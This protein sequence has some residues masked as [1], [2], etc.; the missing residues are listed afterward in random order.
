MQKFVKQ[1]DL[2]IPIIKSGS[3][4]HYTS[5]DGLKGIV[6]GEFWITDREFLNDTKEFHV[7]SKVFKELVKKNIKD[8]G[9]RN[10]IYKAFDKELGTLQGEKLLPKDRCYVLSCSLDCDSILMWSEYSNFMGYCM[11]F[12]AKQFM[13]AFDDRITFQGKV[14]YSHDEQIKI[15]SD[16]IEHEMFSEDFDE[17]T[18]HSWDELEKS[19]ASKVDFFIKHVANVCF[20]YNM[21]FKYECFKQ[22]HEYRFVIYGPPEGIINPPIIETSFRTKDNSI[23]PF[24]KMKLP[25][26][27]GLKRVVIGP[28]NKSDISEKGLKVYFNQKEL[29]V[30]V[31][32]SKVPIRY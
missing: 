25:K 8:R 2:T 3:L 20:L 21:F 23:I 10:S 12:D 27:I 15:V 19:D 22:E 6:D 28:I 31:E 4:F 29:K 16:Y 11:E 14:V 26:D 17:R 24:V 32:R 1:E 9:V 7:A 13:K 18:A 30:K 5:V